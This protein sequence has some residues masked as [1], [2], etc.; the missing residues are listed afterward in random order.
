VTTSDQHI[1]S[2]ADRR[3]GHRAR[4]GAATVRVGVVAAIPEVLI[5]LGVDPA[6]VL[7][8]VGIDPKLFDD[9]NQLISHAARGRLIRHCAARTGCAHFGLLVGQRAGLRSLGLLG[10]LAKYESDVGAALRNLVRFL[11][12]HGRGAGVTL[13][14]DGETARLTYDM[15][16]PGI[17]ATDQIGDGALA[18]LFNILRALCGPEWRPVAVDFAH[19]RPPDIRPFQRFFGAPL[20]F[21]E[22]HHA[23]EFAADW[24]RHPLSEA[25]PELRVLLLE[26]ADALAQGHREDFRAQVRAILHPALLVG[27]CPADRVATL[28]ALHVRTLHR[29]LR[30][31]GTSFRV[32]ADEVRHEIARQLLGDT[33]LGVAEVATAL[34]YADASAFRRAFRRWTATTPSQWRRQR[35]RA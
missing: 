32:L 11:H 33:A 7:G 14:V 9:P 31:E 2:G 8:E 22:E 19:R 3:A 6:E 25:D 24:L 35:R 1:E 13:T 34:G 29:R 15:H 10:L 26:R 4:P 20:Q 16:E 17:E 23:L 30:A 21:D 12:L 28:L 27:R 5:E 18:I